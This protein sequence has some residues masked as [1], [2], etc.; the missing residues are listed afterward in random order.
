MKI[1]PKILML[2]QVYWPDPVAT[3]EYL[4]DLSQNL[5]QKGGKIE[6]WTGK[7]P[8][9]NPDFSYLA[10]ENYG[11]IFIRRLWSTHFSKR[12]FLGRSINFLTFNFSV[13]ARLLAQGWK[14]DVYFTLSSPPF[15]I[16]FSVLVGFLYRKKVYF[17][18]LDLQPD[19]A[20]NSG[21]LH[22][23]SL[24]AQFFRF[25][26]RVSLALSSRI[27]VL[28]RFMAD[29]LKKNY[30][31]QKPIFVSALWPLSLNHYEGEFYQ[32]PFRLKMGFEKRLVVMYAG[33]HALVHP[34]NT[35][36]EAI[37]QLKKEKQFLF[38]FVGSGL[39]KKEVTDF[40]TKNQLENI[41]QL[42]FL[43]REEVHLSLAS[44][45]L[46]VVL[47]GEKMVGLTHPQKIYGAMNSGAAILYIGPRPS[48]GSEILALSPMNLSVQQGEAS[49][50][51][52]KL[53]HFA[54]LPLE[55]RRKI[56]EKNQ[57][58]IQNFF[59]PQKLKDD[60]TNE[61]LRP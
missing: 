46:Q 39:R 28:D 18:N 55:Q 42:P 2:S 15:L 13:L 7:F 12:S 25:L 30:S 10:E 16:F 58:V 19:L 54:A 40:K 21:L 14:W 20:I 33:N 34:M 8:Y 29:F 41:W 36:L 45:D 57:E 48:H 59:P 47:M 3:A 44:A 23:S 1:M 37:L 31:C 61:I 11:Q 22:P 60:L 27:F 38:V 5:S 50:L 35:L 32:N 9:E 24:Q 52:E 49:L 17:W 56:G 51:V 4:F 26:T 43:P 6:V 53:K